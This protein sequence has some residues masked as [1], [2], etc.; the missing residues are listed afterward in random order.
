MNHKAGFGHRF[1]ATLLATKVVKKKNEMPE[2]YGGG[3]R[4]YAV[5]G[6]IQPVFHAGTCA[7]PVRRG[8][9]VGGARWFETP[10]DSVR[11]REVP[12]SDKRRLER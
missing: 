11:L 1:P 8:F 4:E 6:A 9:G 3:R 2:I 5:V 7:V 10:E 12:L